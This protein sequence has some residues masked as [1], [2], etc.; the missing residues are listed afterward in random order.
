MKAIIFDF[1][2]VIRA[3]G[4]LMWL[5]E[6]NLKSDG[7]IRKANDTYC[8]GRISRDEYLEILSSISKQKPDD[9]KQRMSDLAVID[10]EMV[11]LIRKLRE[12]YK[13][14]L[15]TNSAESTR[16]SVEESQLD[17]LFDVMVFSH[18]MGMIKPDFAIYKYALEKLDVLPSEAVFID[19]KLENVE[20]AQR[21]GMEGIVFDGIPKML[22][23]LLQKGVDI[24]DFIG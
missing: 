10:P 8:E 23:D 12:N 24:N 2:G 22:A 1:Y 13:I 14:A 4:Q 9:I 3:D 15:L 19:D 20:A 5:L 18:E 11:E 16:I 6:N 17:R 21:V 7:V